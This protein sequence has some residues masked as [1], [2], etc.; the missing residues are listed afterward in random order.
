MY[1]S[2]LHAMN[3]VANLKYVAINNMTF[4]TT[5]DTILG[6]DKQELEK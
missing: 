5:S 4:N 6:K 3:K 2:I 1:I